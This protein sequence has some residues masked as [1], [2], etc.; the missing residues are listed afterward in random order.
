MLKHQSGFTL[1][2]ALLAIVVGTIAFTLGMRLY[3]TMKLQSDMKQVQAN[4]DSIFQGM[5]AFYQANCYGTSA[6]PGA[7]NPVS[8]PSVNYSVNIQTALTLPNN[9]ILV[10]SIVVPGSGTNGY[11]AQFNEYTR[12]KLVC[13]SGTN[14]IG[15][16][17][18]NCTSSKPVGIVVSWIAQVS[19]QTGSAALASQYKSMLGADC[20]SSAAG[21]VVLECKAGSPG[22]YV[23]WE[24]NPSDI[25]QKA[26]ST[27]WQT[28]PAVK[29][30]TQMYTTDPITILT[31]GY[32]L[33][34]QYYL[35]GN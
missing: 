19:I 5:L 13:T 29:S 16:G 35:C 3:Y 20:T 2:E 17:S 8:N 10:P 15:A 30:F 14:A 32:Q 26:A 1:Y 22:P 28:T 9:L 12:N 34:N 23:V 21:S 33:A 4:V 7:L 25:L 24:K 31:T 6:V 11:I 18:V 27:Y